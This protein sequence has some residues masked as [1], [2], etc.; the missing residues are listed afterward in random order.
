MSDD[1]T[2]DT[3][4]QRMDQALD[5]LVDRFYREVPYAQNLRAG[6][7]LDLGYLRRHTIEIILRLRMKRTVDSLAIRY[8]TKRDPAAAK[9]WSEYTAE[10]MLHD[11]F[12]VKDLQK[13]GVPREVVYA[14]EPLFAT[15]IQ[16]GYYYWALEHEEDPLALLTSVYFMEYV[17]TR[18]QP[19]WLDNMERTV[20]TEKVRG[21]RAHVNLDIDD[22]HPDFVWG[23]LRSLIR[24]EADER[25]MFRHL[26]AIY[27][28]WELFFVELY[29]TTVGQTAVEKTAGEKTAAAQPAAVRAAAQADIAASDLAHAH[30][31][32][33]SS[34]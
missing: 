4:R 3:L 32:P 12:F 31:T 14:T 8:F 17:T 9:A 5:G 33:A 28:L 10:E 2:T 21:A 18:T 22:D 1:N 7:D 27:R 11:A 15:K 20:G 26:D 34:G 13:M 19:E 16:I 24:S 25:R 6:R 29:Q 30:T 23:V